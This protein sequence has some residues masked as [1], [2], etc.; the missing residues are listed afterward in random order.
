MDYYEVLGVTTTASLEDIQG[1][2]RKAAMRWHPEKNP[3][4]READEKFRELAQAYAVLSTSDARKRYDEQLKKGTPA[5]KAQSTVDLDIA[6][7]IFL[8]EMDDL[9]DELKAHGVAKGSIA[10]SLAK[11]GC[12][13]SVA[14]QVAEGKAPGRRMAAAVAKGAQPAP[15]P[16]KQRPRV[17]RPP[18]APFKDRRWALLAH[19]LLLVVAFPF[20]FIPPRTELVPLSELPPAT[21]TAIA[22]T[23]T[24][25]APTPAPTSMTPEPGATPAREPEY[26]AR[27]V[28]RVPN[29]GLAL[30][31]LPI[32]VS[33]VIYMRTRR[34]NEYVATHGLQSA[35]F[36]MLIVAAATALY[37]SGSFILFVGAIYAAIAL[38]FVLVGWEFKYLLI[39]NLAAGIVR[40]V[41]R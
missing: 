30:L 24:A 32:I 41:H 12:P 16:A 1:A 35:I 39:G 38:V 5:E 28:S 20:V 14:K 25:M 6:E 34:T 29:W 33:Y 17:E 40:R 36:Q 4:S 19:G 7:T 18:A 26:V 31:P 27:Y 37:T 15:E 13:D 23:A 10:D 11:R 3:A 8:Q 2:Y 22:A 21:Q 9:A